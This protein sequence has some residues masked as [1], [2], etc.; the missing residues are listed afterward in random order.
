MKKDG[1]FYSI[2]LVS[3]IFILSACR[4]DE[5]PEPTQTGAGTIGCLINGKVFKPRG[6]VF[7]GPRKNCFYEQR[8]NG[9]YFGLSAKDDHENPLRSFSIATDSL[10]VVEGQTIALQTPDT[11]G[12]A[13]AEVSLSPYTDNSI[14]YDKYTTTASVRGELVVSKLDSIRR[15]VSGTF[16]FD[17]IDRNGTKV[18]VRDGR[19][20]MQ[21]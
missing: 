7:G 20:D 1:F 13:W 19:F 12:S 11:K 6:S 9:Y 4:R 17:A 21:Y 2:I 5:L 16:W 8:N 14:T 10:P 18:Q 3:C 15:V